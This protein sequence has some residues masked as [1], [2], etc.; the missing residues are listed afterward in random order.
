MA[1]ETNTA[2]EF[3]T[4]AYKRGLSIDTNPFIDGCEE[5]KDFNKGWKEAHKKISSEGIRAHKQ[6]KRCSPNFNA[7]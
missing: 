3:G 2:K 7:R 1:Y 6:A 4:V 5:A